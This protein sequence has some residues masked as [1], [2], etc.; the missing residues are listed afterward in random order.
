MILDQ[1]KQKDYNSLEVCFNIKVKR[2]GIMKFLE[3]LKLVTPKMDYCAVILRDLT[4]HDILM[5]SMNPNTEIRNIKINGL[6]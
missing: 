5:G 6:R 1:L 3:N 2:K 4:T